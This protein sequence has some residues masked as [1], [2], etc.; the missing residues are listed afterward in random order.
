M[1]GRIA[2]FAVL[3]AIGAFA[4]EG[5]FETIPNPVGSAHAVRGCEDWE[6]VCV[7]ENPIDPNK[8]WPV[9]C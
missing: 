2:L 6:V 4:V 5:T 1:L 7:C 3:L 8:W 9:N